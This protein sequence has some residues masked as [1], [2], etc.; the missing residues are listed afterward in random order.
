MPIPGYAVGEIWARV[1]GASDEVGG[2]GCDDQRESEVLNRRAE[3]V[4]LLL[5]RC[6]WRQAGV[7]IVLGSSSAGIHVDYVVSQNQKQF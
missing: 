6:R 3:H 5:S 4:A 7:Q 2:G 1:A